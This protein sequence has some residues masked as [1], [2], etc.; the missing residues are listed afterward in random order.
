MDL[1]WYRRAR[2]AG[3]T[4]ASLVTWEFRSV[5]PS[6]DDAPAPAKVGRVVASSVGVT[7]DPR[8][9]NATN[10]VVHWSTGL[11]WGVVGAVLASAPGVHPVPAGVAAGALAWITSYAVLP[12]LDIYKPISQY[13]PRVLWDDLSAHLVFGAVTGVALGTLRRI[14][15]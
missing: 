5:P 10:N 11:S 15:A 9:A 12:R 4:P 3:A 14:T 2:A 7:L 8:F 13:E 1:L 6:F